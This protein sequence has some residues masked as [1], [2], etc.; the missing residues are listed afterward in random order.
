MGQQSGGYRDGLEGWASAQVGLT[1]IA[2]TMA[3][4]IDG[5]RQAA[6]HKVH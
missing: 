4:F 1:L 3:T 2:G 6:E 5:I